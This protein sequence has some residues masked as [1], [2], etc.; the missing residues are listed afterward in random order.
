[1]AHFAKL[2]YDIILQEDGSSFMH[3]NETGRSS[4]KLG[5]E[6]DQ[7]I[8]KEIIVTEQD[9][10]NSGS[11][12]DSF[13]WVQTSFNNNFRQR[14]AQKDGMYDR[15]KD[16]FIPKQPYDSWTLDVNNEWQPPTAMPLDGKV[17]TWDEANQEWD[18][19]AH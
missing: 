10:V 2:G 14:Y 17:Y 7:N 18:Y 19:V 1:M 3:E 12:G 15:T 6:S 4:G 16:M 11:I 5:L 8:V 9:I 13:L